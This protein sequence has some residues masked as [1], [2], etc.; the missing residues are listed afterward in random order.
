MSAPVEPGSKG[1]VVLAYSGTLPSHSGPSPLAPRAPSCLPTVVRYRHIP[2]P[3][4]SPGTAPFLPRAQTPRVIYL[5]ADSDPPA[6][7]SPCISTLPYPQADSIPRLCW[8]GSSSRVTMSSATRY[9]LPPPPPPPIRSSESL[10]PIGVLQK[11]CA[12]RS[13]CTLGLGCIG[14]STTSAALPTNCD[15]QTRRGLGA[16]RGS[17]PGMVQESSLAGVL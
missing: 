14:R 1:T 9:P 13:L 6:T 4:P 11:P 8:S 5:P 16:A 10:D 2:A 3:R 12:V 7:P 17:P 15:V